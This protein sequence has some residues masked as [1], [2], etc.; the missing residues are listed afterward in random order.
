MAVDLHTLELHLK[1]LE[2]LKVKD[3]PVACLHAYASSSIQ[4]V[5]AGIGWIKS[6]GWFVLAT[7]GQGPVL[8]WQEKK[9]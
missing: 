2:K 9:V 3:V 1:K 5:S 6:V 4:G 8:V 7:A